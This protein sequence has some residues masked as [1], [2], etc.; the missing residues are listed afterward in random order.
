MKMH[1][2]RTTLMFDPAILRQLR[3]RA[4][5]QD[6]TLSEVTAEVLRLGLSLVEPGKRRKRRVKLPMFSLGKPRVDLS[7]REH[8][9]DILDER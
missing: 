1:M 9:I 2:E 5:E 4:A 7:N 3:R 8:L 6:R